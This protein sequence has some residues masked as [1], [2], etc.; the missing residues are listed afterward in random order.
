MSKEQEFQEAKKKLNEP[1][2]KELF[3]KS[4]RNMARQEA[5]T[6]LKASKIP[7]ER[8]NQCF[9][10]VDVH[11]RM[12][13]NM[14]VINNYNLTIQ[15]IA[16]L[17]T[18]D[19]T[20]ADSEDIIQGYLNIYIDDEEIAKAQS[21]NEVQELLRTNI[22][23]YIIYSCLTYY[24]IY[25]RDR[26]LLKS[27]NKTI[28]DCVKVILQVMNASSINSSTNNAHKAEQQDKPVPQE[29]LDQL[30]EESEDK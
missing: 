12:L 27:Y 28:G 25:H 23:N 2:V 22:K 5:F 9:A 20:W 24:A 18:L 7:D 14:N 1:D 15:V 4:V 13:D 21:Q 26:E 6:N 19:S 3:Q 29:V 10:I 30:N 11:T 8:I 16:N 17:M